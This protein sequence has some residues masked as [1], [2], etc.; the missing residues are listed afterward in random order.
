MLIHHSLI[1][2]TQ[3]NGFGVL[4]SLILILCL[5]LYKVYGELITALPD[6]PSN[7]SFKQYSGYT[8]TDAQHGRALF[9]HF[10]EA[11]PVDPLIRPLTLWLKGG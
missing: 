4:E 5:T 9:Y 8:V 3:Q 7:V 2:F 10:A 6:Q 11:D 1:F